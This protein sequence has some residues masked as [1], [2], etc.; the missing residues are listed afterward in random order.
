M[1][2]SDS[3]WKNF[4]DTGISTGDYIIF[5]QGGPIDNCTHVPSPV[6]QSSS[7]SDYNSACT[8]GM[9]I[10]YFRILNNGFLNK[11]PDVVPKKNSR[12]I[13]YQIRYLH[14]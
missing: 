7:E 9:A 8:A 10:L 12:Y 13:G 11:N 3:I 6:D 2:L 4:P 14:G 1:V 5:Y